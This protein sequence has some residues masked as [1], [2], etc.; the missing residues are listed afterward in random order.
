M[1]FK[2]L[3][4]VLKRVINVT[5]A[6]R[7][8]VSLSINKKTL[9]HG[10]MDNFD[11]TE[12]TSSGIVCSHGTI[13][14]LFQNQNKNENLPKALGQKPTGSPQNQKSLDKILPCQVNLVQE[15]KH[16]KHFR[17]VMK[18]ICHGRRMNL[19]NNTDCGFWLDI[20]ISLPLTMDLTFTILQQ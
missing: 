6:N 16:Q 7:V 3:I 15:V 17:Q 13:L 10:A 9:I 2:G 19:L 5:G 1:S 12:V 4:L 18:E 14:M 8:T 20:K 11:H